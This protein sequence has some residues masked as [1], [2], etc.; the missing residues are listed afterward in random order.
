MFNHL[1]DIDRL[2]KSAIRVEHFATHDIAWANITGQALLTGAW[3]RT[4][5]FDIAPIKDSPIPSIIYQKDVLLLPPDKQV[6]AVAQEVSAL[7]L[8]EPSLS[9]LDALSLL[10]E[11]NWFFICEGSVITGIVT[12]HD[13]ARPAV[14]L[15]LFARIISLEHGLRRLLGTYTNVPIPDMPSVD[16]N[17]TEPRYF[18]ALLDGVG[19]IKELRF[20]LGFTSKNAFKK[21]TGF[22]AD[23]RNHIAH[24]RSILNH[25]PDAPSA[26]EKIQKIDALLKRVSQLTDEREQVWTV[27]ESTYIV[28]PQGTETVWAGSNAITVPMPLPIHVITAFNPFEQVLDSPENERRNSVLADFLGAKGFEFQSVLGRSVT[29][30]WSEP[31]FAIHGMT[32]SEACELG[33]LFGQRAI[34]ELDEDTLRVISVDGQERAQR[35]RSH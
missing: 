30:T 25:V 34:F 2:A 29:G 18:S 28:Q 22:I 11:H 12:R 15:Y 24:G 35:P 6:G 20:S 21:G 14:S 16:P 9:L 32:R 31:S 19:D 10:A 8:V 1:G 27:Y 3:M 33:R 23:L 13:L 17:S 5:D 26:V 4:N 7:Q